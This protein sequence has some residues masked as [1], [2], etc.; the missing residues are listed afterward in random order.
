[1]HYRFDFTLARHFIFGSARPLKHPPLGSSG[2]REFQKRHDGGHQRCPDERKAAQTRKAFQDLHKS[3]GLFVMPNAWNGDSAAMLETAG[4]PAI[5][6]TS[7]GIAFWL[8]LPDC[9]G[10]SSKQAALDVQPVSF[11][12]SLAR[13]TVG[14]I[15][16]RQ[17][18]T[19]PP[20]RT[21]DATRRYFH[22]RRRT[23]P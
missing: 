10:A 23:V 5:G 22:I 17:L 11:G 4:F 2:T 6:T 7:A 8:G 18:R 9:E 3:D 15:G 20:R 16:S 12:G 13:A 19:H 1:M 14:L 21:R